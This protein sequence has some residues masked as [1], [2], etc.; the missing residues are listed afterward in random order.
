MKH[1]GGVRSSCSKGGWQHSCA[2]SAARTRAWHPP[3]AFAAYGRRPDGGSGV[4]RACRG[5]GFD[6]TERDEAAAA[7]G[8]AG[9]DLV[10]DGADPFSGPFAG[11]VAPEARR[12]GGGG[13]GGGFGWRRGFAPA[14]PPPPKR[15]AV[16]PTRRLLPFSGRETAAPVVRSGGEEV[17]RV[18]A[19]PSHGGFGR[20]E[21]VLLPAVLDKVVAA[22]G[23]A[24]A[25]DLYP[26]DGPNAMVGKASHDSVGSAGFLEI[27]GAGWFS[28]ARSD[29][30]HM[31]TL[32]VQAQELEEGEIA[33]TMEIVQGMIK[34]DALIE[35][36][37]LEEGEIAATMDNVEDMNKNVLDGLIDG[38][39]SEEGHIMDIVGVMAK[40]DLDV[41]VEGHEME[42]MDIVV[43]TNKDALCG[44]V[45]GQELEEG[46]IAS[47]LDI[48][49]AMNV[50]T[51]D[52]A[53]QVQEL[54]QGVIAATM[55]TVESMNNQAWHGVVVVVQESEESDIAA[56]MDIVKGTNKDTFVGPV[57]DWESEDEI[58]AKVYAQEPDNSEIA[59][60]SGHTLQQSQFSVHVVPCDSTGGGIMRKK[61]KFTVGKTVQPP[62]IPNHMSQL[63]TLDRPFTSTSANTMK[64]FK[65]TQSKPVSINLASASSLASKEKRK[66]EPV[67]VSK[68]KLRGKTAVYLE[69]DD[70]LNAVAVHGGNLELCLS[71]PSRVRSVWRQGPHGGGQSAGPRRRVRSMCK[72]FQFLCRF[73]AQAVKQGSIKLPRVDLAADHVIKKLP[74]YIKYGSIVGEVDGVEV[75]DEFLFRVE[76]AIVGLH[77]PFRAGIDTTKDTDG[78]P[79]AV[80]IVASGGYLDEYSRS[81]ELIYIGSGG[82]AGGTDQDGD[83][84][85]E[86]GNLALKNCIERGIPV[87]VT[88]GFKTPNKGEGSHSIGKEIPKFIYDGL[89]HV[90]G[91]WQDGVPGSMVFKY[92]LRRIPGQPKLPLH[93]AKWLRKSVVRPR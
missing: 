84:K 25:K 54:K 87:R 72:R 14:A 89:Y 71:A 3:H 45:D 76:L 24:L 1:D 77:N 61:I 42:R 18:G 43:A 36:Q 69:D 12:S 57:E 22:K 31:E 82:N 47:P 65:A 68:E 15:R 37:E 58:A 80:S 50:D 52:G 33:D 30:K 93:V 56:A 21:G 13:G 74:D 23:G 78:E 39:K 2:C 48:V 11:V 60:K 38:H 81:G 17:L 7:G 46:E 75:G 67:F 16:S 62:V 91:F 79:I 5:F 59:T 55:D 27:N 40:E 9:G 8:N 26:P 20:E 83:Q 44:S 92:K 70:V 29:N 64:K 6:G 85:L 34:N 53:V 35:R 51:L 32:A 19:S 49:E 73:L 86:R 66:F 41:P 28:G 88:H 63:V 90:V 10:G 4:S